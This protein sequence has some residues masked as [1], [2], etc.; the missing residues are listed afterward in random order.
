MAYTFFDKKTP[1]GA[2]RLA[3]SETLATQIKY[4]I[5]NESITNKELAEEFHKP[6]I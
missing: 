5:K 3:R 2:A 1:G 4:A 6:I